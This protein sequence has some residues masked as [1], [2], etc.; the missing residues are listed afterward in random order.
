MEI[1]ITI[2]FINHCNR[3]FLALEIAAILC[4]IVNGYEQGFMEFYVLISHGNVFLS[5]IQSC[6]LEIQLEV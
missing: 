6:H 5:H 2:H 4:L 1:A 3:K